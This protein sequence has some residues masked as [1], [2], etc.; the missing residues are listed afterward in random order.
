MSTHIAYRT[1]T[2]HVAEREKKTGSKGEE[3]SDRF[4]P[5]DLDQSAFFGV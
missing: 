5:S 1:D 4:S 2:G 3:G